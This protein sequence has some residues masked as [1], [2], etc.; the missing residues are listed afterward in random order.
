MALEW[1]IRLSDVS[2]FNGQEFAQNIKK[3][4]LRIYEN[5]GIEDENLRKEVCENIDKTQLYI[6]LPMIYYGAE[7]K[8]LFSA[9]V[10][11]KIDEFVSSKA[12]KKIFAFL[13]FVYENSKTKP[14][15]K[16]ASEIFR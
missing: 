5:I 1:D 10:V 3:T 15:M 7:L 11:P 12:G 2:E 13:N 6:C 4:F 16:I 14:F 9:Q 8:G